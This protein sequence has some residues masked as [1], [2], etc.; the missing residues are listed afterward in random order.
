MATLNQLKTHAMD[1][2]IT[3]VK[4][5]GEYQFRVTTTNVLLGRIADL[6]TAYSKVEI[7]ATCIPSY[8]K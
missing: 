3:I 1:N 7:F 6:Q 5:Y 8:Q 4:K 2:G